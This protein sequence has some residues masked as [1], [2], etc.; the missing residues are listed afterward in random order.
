MTRP[1]DVTSVFNNQHGIDNDYSLREIL[2]AFGVKPD[3]LR[4]AWH[5]PLKGDWC[6]VEGDALNPQHMCFIKW[7]Q[8]S[9]RK[10]LLT[11]RTL[12]EMAGVFV[13]SLLDTMRP[14]SITYCM[15]GEENLYS[16]YT[17]IR[18][19]MVEASA[20]SMFGPHLHEINPDVIEH[21]LRFND[22]A[23]QVVMRYP[24]FL[25]RLP[26]SEP[27][28][29]MMAVMRGLV[30]RHSSEIPLANAFVRNVLDRME[31][32]EITTHSRAA[33]MLMIFWA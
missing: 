13:D 18:N 16:L 12:E 3:D 19:A 17:I 23:W 15:M 5:M 20:Q 33:M 4:R 21:M 7:V 14:E 22:N 29:K 10:H 25:G 1:E 8:D 9:Y 27:R 26:V 28:K 32:T 30:Q 6:Y 31:L 2:I 11:K 24:D